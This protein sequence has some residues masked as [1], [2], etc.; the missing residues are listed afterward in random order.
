MITLSAETSPNEHD[1]IAP[2][3]TQFESK[4]IASLPTKGIPTGSL[5]TGGAFENYK[6][7]VVV[8]QAGIHYPFKLEKGTPN[9]HVALDILREEGYACSIVEEALSMLKSK[10]PR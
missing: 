7:S 10:S 6:V 2:F 5:P 9:Q 8:D 3:G 4:P 1:A